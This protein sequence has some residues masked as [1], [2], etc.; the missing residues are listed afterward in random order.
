MHA[1]L[2]CGRLTAPL[3]RR[4]LAAFVAVATLAVV[5]APALA[6]HKNTKE[7]GLF[8]GYSLI[9]D[10]TEMG[11]VRTGGAGPNSGLCFGGR[12]GVNINEW[13]GVEGEMK[14][15]PTDLADNSASG[16]IF[17]FRA[18]GLLHYNMGEEASF[19]P[20]LW[21]GFGAETLQITPRG[22]VGDND[23]VEQDTDFAPIMLGIGAKYL[24]LPELLVRA[25]FRAVALPDNSGVPNSLSPN[26]EFLV[27]A[28]WVL[29]AGP[30]DKDKDGIVDEKDKCP[31]KPEDKDGFEDS[32]GCPDPDND[33]DGILD[34]A[35]KCKDKAEDK[36]GFEDDDGCPDPD[37]DGDGIEDAKDKC[38]NKAEDKDGFDDEDGCP[39]P[40]ND[41]DGIPDTDDKCPNKFGV[42]S[43]QG[44]PVVDTDKDGIPDKLDKCP[45]KPETF[46][47]IKDEDGCPERTKATVIITKTEIKIL[48]KV[49]FEV[50]KAEIKKKSYELLNTV[51]AVLNSQMQI[52]EILVEGHT[53]DTGGDADNLKLSDERAKSVRQYM[54]DKGVKAERL[55]AKGFGETAP[56]CKDVPELLKKKR[57]NRKKLAKCRDEN[58]RVTFR[59]TGMN[60]K[61]VKAGESAVIETKTKVEKIE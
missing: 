60:G 38:P 61:P 28:S 11:N 16:T 45:T 53:D 37:N 14:I 41:K 51:S 19:R 46:N 17:G 9:S 27:G 12:V 42:A 47:G 5:T 49:Y 39:D 48:Q 43:E 18:G 50:G 33:G 10:D 52:T 2:F 13:L 44:C 6:K 32:D 29:G 21:G 59:I 22:Q 3:S 1:R 35:D 40:D 34:E 55:V 7:V 36:D 8:L 56:V 20:F 58:R 54:I 57:K 30:R 24:V 25:D 23:F 26:W 4:L 15:H 31:M